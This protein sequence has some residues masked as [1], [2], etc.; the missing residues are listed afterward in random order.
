MEECIKI[1]N[2]RGAYKVGESVI[3]TGRNLKVK[4]VIHTVGPR[5]NN[6][7][8]NEIDK[9]RNA[10]LNSMNLADRNEFR[11]IAFPNISTGIYKFPKGL[12]AEITMKTILESEGKNLTEVKFVCFDQDN[13]DLYENKLKRK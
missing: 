8:S 2:K 10:Y 7:N 12:A 4:K 9:L 3:T 5:W 11:S 1:R 13:Y 6:G